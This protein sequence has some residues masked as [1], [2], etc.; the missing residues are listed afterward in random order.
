MA[1]SKI[2]QK[3]FGGKML[4]NLIYSKFLQSSDMY[5]EKATKIGKNLTVFLKL[6]F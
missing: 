4:S 3:H 1:S 6:C 2:D 5:C